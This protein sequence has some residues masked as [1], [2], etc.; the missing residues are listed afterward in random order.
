MFFVKR[1]IVIA[2]NIL[3]FILANYMN[4]QNI[5]RKKGEL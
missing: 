2:S 3:C 4:I 5:F 1:V